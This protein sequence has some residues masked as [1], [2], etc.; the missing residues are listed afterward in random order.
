MQNHNAV[1]FANNDKEVED[2]LKVS[3]QRLVEKKPPNVI[4]DLED[5]REKK[6]RICLRNIVKQL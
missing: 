1:G 2:L 4:L 3:L 5:V 6:C